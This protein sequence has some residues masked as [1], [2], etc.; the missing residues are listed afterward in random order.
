[1]KPSD[2]VKKRKMVVTPSGKAKIRVIRHKK[3]K[4]SCAITKK[5]IT[6]ANNNPLLSKT[7]KRPSVIFGGVLSVK[8]RNVVFENT[9]KVKLGIKKEEDLNLTTKKYVKQAIKKVGVNL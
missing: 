6:S 5:P 2:R 7:E 8:A 1:M 4:V 9:I 3:T